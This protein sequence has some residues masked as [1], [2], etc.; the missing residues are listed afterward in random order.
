[1]VPGYDCRSVVVSV[2]L[3][4]TY[5]AEMADSLCGESRILKRKAIH[6]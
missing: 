4:E 2:L 3:S 6:V 1:M 5:A